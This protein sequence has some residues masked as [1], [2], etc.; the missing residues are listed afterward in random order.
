MS[1]YKITTVL[2]VDTNDFFFANI[3]SNY[4]LGDNWVPVT[5]YANN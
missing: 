5:S 1:E 2:N 4:G 3:H